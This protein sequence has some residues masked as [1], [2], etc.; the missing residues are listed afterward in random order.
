MSNRTMIVQINGLFRW[1]FLMVGVTKWKY[2]QAAIDERQD[3]C[4]H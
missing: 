4:D 2:S 3:M 1:D